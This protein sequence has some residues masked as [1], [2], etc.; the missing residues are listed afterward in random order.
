MKEIKHFMLPEHTNKLYENEAISSISLTRD[1]AE[2]INELVDAYNELS[3][4][5]LEKHQEQ[6]GTIRKGILY[7]KDNLINTLYDLTKLLESDGFFEGTVSKYVKVLES[8]VNNLIGSI[9]E[10]STT[11]DAE[12]I[13]SRINN[14]GI[15]YTTAGN[16]IRALY[17]A[18]SERI[19]NLSVYSLDLVKMQLNSKEIFS[20]DIEYFHGVSTEKWEH[21][22]KTFRAPAGKYT[23]VL[24]ACYMP[25]PGY[26]K[27]SH[28]TTG[29]KFTDAIT[30]PGIY[31]FTIYDVEEGFEERTILFQTS[32]EELAKVGLY[33]ARGIHIFEGWFSEM[34]G[35]PDYFTGADKRL[36]KI[37]GKN[38]FN[39][40]TITPGYYLAGSGL[41]QKEQPAY[42]GYYY[43]DYMEV[44]PGKTYAITTPYLGGGYIAFYNK[45]DAAA[46]KNPDGSYASWTGSTLNAANGIITAP[47]DAK[48]LRISGRVID[49]YNTQ[50]EKGSEKTPFEPYTEYLPLTLL[51]MRVEKLES[52]S[53]DA[54]TKSN[55][56]EHAAAA[57]LADGES[58]SIESPHSKCGH[59]IGFSAE[60]DAFSGELTISH[61]KTNP[62]CSAYMV[63]SAD[64]LKVYSF[65]SAAKLLATYEHGLNL[66]GF[67]FIDITTEY[68]T[69]NI[70][71]SSNGSVYEVETEWNGSNGDIMAESSGMTLK[72]CLLSYYI[73]DLDKPIWLFGDSYFDHWCEYVNEYGYS[74]AMLDAYSGRGS[75]QAISSLKKCL[76]KATPKKIAWFMG[77]NDADTSTAINSNWLSAVNTLKTLCENNGIELILSTVPNT[78]ERSHTFKNEYI[79][80]SGFRYIDVCH[81]VGADTNTNWNSGLLSGDNVH[82]SETGR[83]VMANYILA[84]LPEIKG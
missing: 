50:V 48:F 39:P 26:L 56:T 2:K 77:M 59:S 17:T 32:T 47:A 61:G 36:P 80:K 43:S 70:R 23:L 44:E 68:K 35:L 83:L 71:I 24:D 73:A 1:V 5:D 34:Q 16:A 28:T 27:I 14:E 25:E 7:M 21:T 64:S 30:K 19:G 69:A 22:H 3:Q 6:D 82:A 38:I 10:G 66:S 78:P 57:T 49:I 62:F 18:L 63:L 55:T 45:K 84:M 51:E 60:F 58:V 8:R 31:E 13:D 40:E 75:L 20:G 46:I 54:G 65:E 79:K 12:V 37:Y 67:V 42:P 33:Y 9:K 74:G 53:E 41:P 81:A 11:L 52:L 29:I 76:E 72:N 15:V 4:W